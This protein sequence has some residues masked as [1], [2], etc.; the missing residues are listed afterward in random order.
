M[1]V[2]ARKLVQ[3]I[4]AHD[5]DKTGQR[6]CFFQISQCVVGIVLGQ[7]LLGSL[8]PQKRI[9]RGNFTSMYQP[10]GKGFHAGGAFEWILRA[11]KPPDLIKT[12]GAACLERNMNVATMRWIERAAN[13]T[14]FQ[15]R[16]AVKQQ[17]HLMM[18]ASCVSGHCHEQHI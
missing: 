7:S 6:H 13:K 12:Q 9:G 10:C 2:P 1:P 18:M 11:D 8:N 16:P 14:N 15:A 17:W 4:R 3:I 5:P